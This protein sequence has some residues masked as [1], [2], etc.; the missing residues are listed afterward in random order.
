KDYWPVGGDFN[1]AVRAMAAWDP[2]GAGGEREMMVVGG[3]FTEIGGV[4]FDHIAAWRFN[5]L[6][7]RFEWFDLGGADGPVNAI[8]TYT[9]PGGGNAASIVVGGSFTALGGAGANLAIGD[10]NGSAIPGSSVDWAAI[11][12]GTNGPVYALSIWDPDTADPF[13][14]V[15]VVVGGDFTSPSPNITFV[16]P[17]MGALVFED[18]GGGTNGPV[19]ALHN[20][21]FWDTD[22]MEP[23]IRSAIYAGG[24]FSQVGGATPASNLAAFFVY[25]DDMMNLVMMWKPAGAGTNGPVYALEVWDRDGEDENFADQLAIGGDF[26]SPGPFVAAYQNDENVQAMS[27]LSGG[28]NAPV[29]TLH[30][31]IDQEFDTDVGFIVESP[32]LYAG[33]EFTFVDGSLEALRLASFKF[34][35]NLFVPAYVWFAMGDGTDNTVFALASMNDE[36]AG[37]WDRNDRHATRV[38]MVIGG[39]A[40][41]YV[42]MFLRVY[43]SNFD[44]I[45]TNDTIQPPLPDPAGMLDFSL[46]P[47]M[48]TVFEGIQVWGG[49]TYYIELT[50]LTSTGRYTLTVRTDAQQPQG[51]DVISRHTEPFPAGSWPQASEILL[52]T[53]SGGVGDGRNFLAPQIAA[54]NFRSYEITP[55]GK[56]VTQVQELAAIEWIQD[57][58]LYKFRAPADGTAEI[59]IATLQISDD[60]FEQIVDFVNGSTETVFKEKTLNSFFDS[61]LK[62]YD[63]DF[64]LIAENDDNAAVKGAMELY[65]TGDFQRWFTQR[66]ARIVINVQAGQE[67]FIEVSSAQLRSLQA[68]PSTVEWR[69]A[70]G[71]YELLINSMPN[72][73]PFANPN[74]GIPDDHANILGTGVS[75]SQSTVIAMDSAAG[76]GSITGVID[77]HI[78]NPFD[79]DFFQFIAPAEGVASV[80]VTPTGAGSTLNLFMAIYDQSGFLLTNANAPAGE[81]LT[82]G[83]A[84]LKGDQFY[85]Q[86]DGQTS[87]NGTYRID[88]SGLPFSDDHASAGKW[89]DA[90]ELEILDFLGIA[91]DSGRIEAPG[92]I[93][94][95]KFNTL[96]FDIAE[97][98]LTSLSSSLDPIV[99]VYEI[100]EDRA[101]NP[102]LLQ[103]AFNDN[104]PNSLNSH[105][106]FPVTAPERTS[107]LTGNTYNTY[108]IVVAGVDPNADFGDYELSLRI[109]PTDDHPDDTQFEF[110]SPVIVDSLFGMGASSGILEIS[111]DTDLFQFVSPAGGP[112]SITVLSDATSTLRP[113]LWVYDSSFNRLTDLTTGLQVVTGDDAAVSTATFSFTA[114]RNQT[115]LFVIGGVSGGSVTVD[116]GSYTVSIDAP[117]ADDHANRT[118]FVLATQILLSPETGDGAAVGTIGQETDTDLFFFETLVGDDYVISIDAAVGAFNP[119]VEL[120]DLSQ[121]SIA[122]VVDGGAGDEDGLRNGS[123]V[124]TL[125]AGAAGEIYYVLVSSDPAGSQRTGD[126]AVAIDGEPPTTPPG[127]PDDDHADAG[128]FSLATVISLSVRTGDGLAT[129]TIEVS[130]DTDLFR[131][132]SLASGEAF[133]QIVA[134][135][136][137]LLDAELRVYNQ[138]EQLIRFDSEGVPGAEAS[139]AFP[140]TGVGQVF[141]L[142]V[143]GVGSSFGSYSVRVNTA[144]EVFHLYFPEGF[145]NPDIR[146]FVSLANPN[147]F[148]VT[149]EITLYYENTTL[150]PVTVTPAGGTQLSNGARGGI[151]LSGFGAVLDGVAPNEPYS[152]QITS[153]GPLGAVF[154]H[155]DFGLALGE[156]FTETASVV[157]SFAS[158]TRQPGA[159]NDFLV[160]F[161]PNPTDV[162]VT[163]TAFTS[164]GQVVLTQ[165][166]GGNRRGGWDIASTSLLPTETFGVVITSA[167]V[168]PNDSHIG[169]VASL[170]HF[171]TNNRIGYS[172]MG[173]SNGGA[174]RGV[175]TSLEN[176][177]AVT[178]LVSLFNAGPSVV[179]V[180]LRSSYTQV[181]LPDVIKIVEIQAGQTIALDAAGLGLT[182][183]QPV[184]LRYDATGKVTVLATESFAGEANATRAGTDAGMSFFF[185]DAFINTAS[186]GVKYLETLGFYNPS[187]TVL[188]VNVELFFL[189]GDT[190]TTQVT[191]AADGFATL[192][193]HELNLIL[194]RGGLQFFAIEVSAGSPF[195]VEM[196][197]YDLF[198]G[199]GWSTGGAPLGLLNSL[200]SMG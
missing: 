80:T 45:Y 91:T 23:V 8:T 175:V 65:Q 15:G 169:I 18:M 141:Y 101:G 143:G 137:S 160:F 176:T 51:I 95:F 62:V 42:N 73:F 10:W 158:V 96:T 178:P 172:V 98:T 16:R 181:A 32:V 127:P 58:D 6:F 84:A 150:A 39:T 182:S 167:P 27:T 198:L 136:G 117:T 17:E 151:T 108:Y 81:S 138:A 148:Q 100:Q 97:I 135:D 3:D 122:I 179:S 72:L 28:M 194:D 154:A 155:Y 19:Y 173:D 70:T 145:A 195:I 50:S 152:I 110:A 184:G 128:E 13:G 31:F 161:N 166:L 118:E 77:N 35:P 121:N 44:L 111:G 90:T 116:N 69:S 20:Y 63:N 93:D 132:T 180:T 168:D 7:Q 22:P 29:R 14:D 183:N 106:F 126:Y 61:Y 88:V 123:V 146:E 33:G 177:D 140:S 162:R 189:N 113:S 54:F 79:I 103:V 131:F 34:N 92:D 64:V 125:T 48:P 76:T 36:I 46:A 157:W 87:S 67:Y 25:D 129:G 139:T 196:T 174:T 56:G 134:P 119:I 75:L 153:N 5:P 68:D 99:R 55:S 133:V 82:L 102:V 147:S 52:S 24:A 60:F 2:D 197:H 124:T 144:P 115:Y 43:D 109:S 187:G 156:S 107:L 71:G 37:Q 57:T 78:F 86:I 40:E 59:R 165:T 21:T 192:K 26:T 47:G 105:T 9:L 41:A 200:S 171:D 12:G 199:G 193:L 74:T 11:Q 30:A 38:S 1:G 120:F 188:T 142:E 83:V 112:A 94:L 104:E 163:M 85:V 4:P 149:Y 53:G 191:L 164:R 89:L 49:E 66:D 159:V 130:G 170:S 185:G 190:A 186:A 114:V